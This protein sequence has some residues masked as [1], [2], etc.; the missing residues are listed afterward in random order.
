MSYTLYL[1]EK[2]S[3]GEVLAQFLAK[4]TGKPA[5]KMRDHFV[6]GNDIRVGWLRGHLLENVSPDVYDPALKD[7]TASAH[8]LPFVPNPFQLEVKESA[9]SLFSSAR[10]LALEAAEIV[11][12]AD[13]DDQGELLSVQF[14]RFI[15]IKSPVKRLMAV[16]L[17]DKGLERS[18]QSIKSSAAFEGNYYSALAQSHADWLYGINMTRACTIE[19]KKRGSNLLFNV[20]RVKTPLWA[21]IVR[22]ELAIRSFCAQDYFKPWIQLQA[23]PAFKA[24]WVHR[25][26]DPR[27]DADGR[28][29]DSSV[30]AQLVA[31]AKGARQAVVTKAETKPAQEHAPLPF[32]LNTL[33][34]YCSKLFQWSPSQTLEIAQ[35]LYDKKLIS[36]PRTALEYIPEGQ[37]E[38]AGD[39]LASLAK[40]PLPTSF[41]GALRGA[42]L[43]VRSRAFDDAKLAKASHYAIVPTELSN[44]A[45]VDQLSEL[46]K[47]AYFEIVRRYVLQFWPAAKV[48]VTQITL[49]CAKEVYAAN[50]KRY[51]DE[52]WRKAFVMQDEAEDESSEGGKDT[53]QQLPALTAG[54]VLPLADV[55]FDKAT[56][57]SPKRYTQGTL[58]T[59]MSRVHT[60]VKDPKIRERLREKEGLGTEATRASIILETVE[61]KLF[62]LGGKA[63]QEIIPSDDVIKFIGLLPESMTAPD[64]TALWQLYFDGIKE[65]CNSYGDF[66][67]QQTAWLGKMVA[68]V[69]KFFE[70]VNFEG[71]HRADGS[72]AVRAQVQLTDQ[73]CNACEAPLKRINGKYGWFWACSNEACKKLFTDMAGMPVERKEPS[74]ST[75]GCPKCNEHAKTGGGFLRRLARRDGSGYFWGCTAYDKGC[76]AGFNDVD[77]SPDLE[78]ATQQGANMPKVACPQ[79][80]QGSL[81][82]IAKK[83][84][85][86]GY[87]WGCSRWKEGCRAGFNDEGGQP[88]LGGGAPKGGGGGFGSGAPGARALP[89]M[90]SSSH[91]HTPMRGPSFTGAKEAPV[92]AAQVPRWGSSAG[93][94]PG[95]V[96]PKGGKP[97]VH[98][99]FADKARRHGGGVAYDPLAD[100]D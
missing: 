45:M 2:P 84:K 3:A 52:G 98:I 32:A 94:A 73:P 79:C 25:K 43:D 37:H 70:S 60:E 62:S 11:N 51:L 27:V 20:G 59:A 49:E 68:G 36:Y 9:K 93:G 47:K 8:R 65:G 16:D 75:I 64:M 46:E 1:A 61:H 77:G 30:A 18:L 48:S 69:S 57:T 13:P 63:K 21:M 14:L 72:P 56:T 91:F 29:L 31:A 42:K 35:A 33:Q 58:L 26:E 92:A 39:I 78:G 44:P 53:E 54:M 34:S 40:A 12:C 100:L 22:R 19:A 38:L 88:D 67:A 4:R 90:K 71:A 24:M 99:S 50:G 76:K 96:K 95:T 15:G 82:R 7:W 74:V 41:T 97:A 81:R 85:A 23:K 28:L 66:I 17:T 87:F 89:A 83:D 5:A 55:G 10:T 86:A 80:E 6:I